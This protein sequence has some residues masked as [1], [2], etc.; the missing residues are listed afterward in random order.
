MNS[1]EMEE[2]RKDA[3]ELCG[4]ISKKMGLGRRVKMEHNSKYGYAFTNNNNDGYSI[5]NIP[6]LQGKNYEELGNDI[7]HELAH[8]DMYTKLP[9][10]IK[11]HLI[12]GDDCCTV[13]YIGFHMLDEYNAYK[14][15]EQYYHINQSSVSAYEVNIQNYFLRDFPKQTRYPRSL[16]LDWF[17]AIP[18]VYFYR[19]KKFMGCHEAFIINLNKY[20]DIMEN[21]NESTLKWEEYNELFHCAAEAIYYNIQKEIKQSFYEKTQK[22]LN[23]STSL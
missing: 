16:F 19:N 1:Q 4:I 9:E 22:I 17:D 7:A 14:N 5:I 10:E 3:E 6:L 20:I 2:M 8:V 13:N 21:T 23:D 11:Q 15:A 18:K 12:I